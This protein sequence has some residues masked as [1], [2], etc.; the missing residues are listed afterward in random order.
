MSLWAEQGHVQGSMED[1][2]R[3]PFGGVRLCRA[4]RRGQA[5]SVEPIRIFWD[6]FVGHGFSF[7]EPYGG[8]QQ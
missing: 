4:T 3:G 7:A 2:T 5:E 1:R 8:Y 6:R